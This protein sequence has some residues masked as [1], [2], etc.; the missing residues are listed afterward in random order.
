MGEVS[1]TVENTNEPVNTGSE[2]LSDIDNVSIAIA[3][4]SDDEFFGEPSKGK[5]VVKKE[6]EPTKK[7]TEPEKEDNS[8]KKEDISSKKG[9][10]PSEPSKDKKDFVFD[11]DKY[12]KMTPEELVKELENVSKNAHEL[13]S[14]RGKQGQ[15]IGQS[16]ETIKNL[17]TE[18]ENLKKSI[19][20]EDKLKEMG[21]DDPVGAGKQAMKNEKI[22]EQIDQ[23]QYE[24]LYSQTQ[25]SLLEVAPDFNEKIDS[26][27][28][29]MKEDGAKEKTVKQFKD[30]PFALNPAVLLNL[31][32][33]A[34]LKD[35]F[36]ADI[37][38]KNQELTELQKKYDT[39]IKNTKHVTQNLSKSV[40][41]P[42]LGN[43]PSETV[44]KEKPLTEI[45]IA[46]MADD[47]L[48]KIG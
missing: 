48:E 17:Q 39:L 4:M 15:E 20:D 47:E 25:A 3:S 37:A 13:N 27:A 41:M 42:S 33:R 46:L 43:L 45:E 23:K 1:E 14:L 16:R 18:I 31:Y 38:L 19:V 36:D 9:K 11:K 40:K 30:Q 6:E 2:K 22:Q 10:E 35:K 8:L 28:E 44:G 29:M 24:I 5:E 12:S 34:A 26:I 21:F 7:A 32:K